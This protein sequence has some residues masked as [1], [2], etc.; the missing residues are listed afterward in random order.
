MPVAVQYRLVLQMFTF[1]AFTIA[2]VANFMTTNLGIAESGTTYRD[3]YG[4]FVSVCVVSSLGAAGLLAMLLLYMRHK[5]ML[6]Y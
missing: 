1:M 4:V 3:S 6:C 5:R 2:N